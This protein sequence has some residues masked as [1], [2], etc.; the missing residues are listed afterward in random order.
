MKQGVKRI[1]AFLLALS[2]SMSGMDATVLY[3]E[4]ESSSVIVTPFQEQ[5]KYFGQ[6]RHLTEG[7]HYILSRD[8]EQNG[9]WLSL[10]SEAVG[11]QKFVLRGNPGDIKLAEEEDPAM[12]EVRPYHADADAKAAAETGTTIKTGTTAGSEISVINNKFAE[13]N[14]GVII[15]APE[16]YLINLVC[17]NDAVTF[18]GSENPADAGDGDSEEWK[19]EIEYPVEGIKTIEEKDISVQYYLRSCKTDSTRNA[20]DQ[21][22]RTLTIHKDTKLPDVKLTIPEE[23]EGDV[24]AAVSLTSDEPGTYYYLA[25]PEDTYNLEDEELSET[26]Q[27][28]VKANI[29]I[30]GSG[31]MN[32]NQPITLDIQK[33]SPETNYQI[34][35]LVIDQAGNESAIQ[36]ESFR[37]NKMLLKGDVSIAGNAAVDSIL[38]AQPNPSSTGAD[39]QQHGSYQWYRIQWS[40]D[41]GPELSLDDADEI[42]G[43]VLP[44]YRVTRE[45]IGYR[46]IVCVK[47]ETYSGGILGMTNTSVP[48]LVPSCQVPVVG[49]TSY[50]P[51]KQL[52]SI[53]LSQNWQWVDS[54]LTPEYG[55]EGYWA[56]YI[57]EES[58]IYESVRVR[59]KVPVKRRTI[60]KSW[61]KLASK[62]SYTGKAIKDNFTVR[63]SRYKLVQ[64]KDYQVTYYNN[65]ELGKAT[66]KIKGIGNY[67]GSVR[68]QYEI[69]QKSIKNLS[70]EYTKTKTYTGKHLKIWVRLINQTSILK[71]G[72]DYTVTYKNN[73]EIG[74]ASLTIEG[75]GNYKGTKKLSFSIIPPKPKMKAK[76]KGKG[77]QIT[78]SSDEETDGYLI[79]VSDSKK[80]NTK[81]TQQYF[82]SG[83]KFEI[84]SLPKGTYYFRAQAKVTKKGKDYLSKGCLKGIKHG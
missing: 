38:T 24:S 33:L 74:K 78:L 15:Q 84:S 69:V 54:S 23:N 20:I 79:S 13:E 10:E 29:G 12:L 75:T 71:E 22:P 36:M 77:V 83:S 52:S 25:A 9:W 34:F 21:E 14:E 7:E 81:Q 46:L 6:S 80:F 31:R 47:E 19:D 73:T 35:A 16:G 53:A 11:K 43:A 27:N 18:S 30:V 44:T 64:G 68:L 55:S 57:P 66:I 60:K 61:V 5:W 76:S 56:E 8:A 49:R 3:A 42:E 4:E 37:T 28:S 45:D 32:G 50:L 1:V 48:K 26:I 67:Q 70:C 72:H 40:E 17:E 63:D 82:V 41:D 2:V 59:I 65:K 39:V 62:A 51:T 58:E